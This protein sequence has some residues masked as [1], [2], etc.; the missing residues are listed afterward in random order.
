[1]RDAPED[2]GHTSLAE[3][4][5]KSIFGNEENREDRHDV[6]FAGTIQF[7]NGK[8]RWWNKDMLNKP[9]RH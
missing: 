6:Y 2:P 9:I 3:V 4:I 1:M 7:E 5:A 8:I